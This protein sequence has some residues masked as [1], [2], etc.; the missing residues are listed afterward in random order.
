MTRTP[1]AFLGGK[2]RLYQLEDGYRAGMDAAVLIAALNLQPGQT[3]MEFGC[4]AG[5]A[6]LGA[7]ALYDQV[8]FI[9]IEL[10]T[11][12]A[13]LAQENVALN[14]MTGR[15]RVIEG[16]ALG[17]HD[18]RELDAVFFNPPFFDD[19][20]AL[21]APKAGKTPAWMSDAGLVAWI[22]TGL[23]RLKSGGV[24]TLIQRADRLDDILAALK[25]RAGAVTVL[26]IHVRSDETAK[27]VLVQATKT[28][29]AP[30]Q[31]RPPL[32]LHQAGETGFTAE[33]DALFRGEL[34]LEFRR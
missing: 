28:G 27:R 11:K 30:L 12:A 5:A 19:P 26:P 17:Y 21:R 13:A 18:A 6:L 34:R 22:D 4:G 9:G 2:I 10:D 29:K 14:D 1:D 23:R 20:T 32:V 24:I 3:A 8:Q 7:A 25:G 31:I 15:V 16:D 33:A